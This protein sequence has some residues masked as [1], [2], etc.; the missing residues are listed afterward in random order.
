MGRDYQVVKEQKLRSRVAQ[1]RVWAGEKV[2]SREIG[3]G[4]GISVADFPKWEIRLSARS[5]GQRWASIAG[6]SVGERKALAA[7]AG[8]PKIG[9]LHS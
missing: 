2:R 7:R 8:A 9:T 1:L 6:R 4:S 3:A 5:S